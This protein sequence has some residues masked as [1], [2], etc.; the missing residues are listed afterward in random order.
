MI[1][2]ENFDFSKIN[3]KELTEELK[4]LGK[5]LLKPEEVVSKAQAGESLAGAK[6]WSLD[7]SGADLHGINLEHAMIFKTIFKGANL[8]NANLAHAVFNEADLGEVNLTKANL[9]Y[10]QMMNTRVKPA[11]TRNTLTVQL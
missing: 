2:F 8:E 4:N 3:I 11:E 7:L 9:S 1:D 6:L 5:M 10:A